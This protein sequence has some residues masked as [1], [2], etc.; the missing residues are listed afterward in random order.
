MDLRFCLARRSNK[1]WYF[2]VINFISRKFK[3]GF[4]QDKFKNYYFYVPINNSSCNEKDLI[5]INPYHFW[6]LNF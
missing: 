2:K 4:K 5:I 3:I 1:N 6:E